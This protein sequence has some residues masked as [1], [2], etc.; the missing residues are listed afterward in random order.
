[1]KIKKKKRKR[2]KKKD[3]KK[4][5]SN[6]G[7]FYIYNLTWKRF[8]KPFLLRTEGQ[9]TTITQSEQNPSAD[10]APR[11]EEERKKTDRQTPGR[12]KAELG[13]T[14]RESRDPD[15]QGLRESCLLVFIKS[16]FTTGMLWPAS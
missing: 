9:I 10:A 2:E 7:K 5:R 16:G 11:G 6:N 3:F 4:S 8:K 12:D 13:P 14:N 15:K 1:M